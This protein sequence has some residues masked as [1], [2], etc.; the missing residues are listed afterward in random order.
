MERVFGIGPDHHQRPEDRPVLTP[1]PGCQLIGPGNGGYSNANSWYN[2]VNARSAV[3]ITSDNK[4]V[5]FTV[6]VRPNPTPPNPPAPPNPLRSQGM[7]VGEVADVL[8]GYKVVNALNV[9]GG[10]STTMAMQDTTDPYTRRVINVPSDVPPRAEASSLAVYSDAIDPVSTATASPAANAYG[11]NNTNINVTLKASDLRSGIAGPLP[12]WVDQAQYSMEGAQAVDPTVVPGQAGSVDVT[13][14]VTTDGAT[15]VTYFATDAAGNDEGEKE[16]TVRI[17]R[18]KPE[19]E[20]LPSPDCSIWPPNHEMRQVA[21][22]SAS[23]ALSGVAPGTLQ[24][25]A[26]SSDPSNPDDILVAPDG[27]GGFAVWLRA[28][29][30]GNG[31]GRVYAINATAKDRAG[32]EQTATTTCVVPHDQGTLSPRPWFDSARAEV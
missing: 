10:G 8:L 26:T 30:R 16:L 19:I 13:V 32:N 5:L 9:D 6:D 11:W 29:R 21:V 20:G 23:D 31:Q 14:G 22:V 24:V 7:R 3:G 18:A 28:E 12:G 15:T 2:L 17:D 27:A 25:T 4:L 1:T